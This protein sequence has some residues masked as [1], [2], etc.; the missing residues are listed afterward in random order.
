MADN[1]N[2]NDLLTDKIAKFINAAFSVGDPRAKLN[3]KIK[4]VSYAA[5][6]ADTPEKKAKLEAKLNKLYEK[7]QKIDDQGV[8]TGQK[9]TGFLGVAAMIVAAFVKVAKAGLQSYKKSITSTQQLAKTFKLINSE[10]SAFGETLAKANAV[11]SNQ[12]ATGK[13]TNALL[14]AEKVAAN[15]FVNAIIDGINKAKKKIVEFL[16]DEDYTTLLAK[17]IVEANKMAFM[18]KGYSTSQIADYSDTAINYAVQTARGYEGNKGLNADALIESD[19]YK[20]ALER[21]N[22]WINGGMNS[23]MFQGG[24]AELLGEDY[25][26][27]LIMSAEVQAEYTKQLVDK[28]SKMGLEEQQSTLSSWENAGTILNN[29]AKNL[30]SFDEVISQDA[31]KVNDEKASKILEG[32]I[33][34]YDKKDDLLSSI[35]QDVEKIA[36]GEMDSSG[37]HEI[38][39]SD[40]GG[41]TGGEDHT[42]FMADYL[43]NKYSTNLHGTTINADTGY[44]YDER[45]GK[46]LSPDNTGTGVNKINPSF[47]STSS[48]NSSSNGFLDFLGR[49]ADNFVSILTGSHGLNPTQNANRN[50]VNPHF[51]AGGIGR[52]P[53]TNA[54]LFENGAE[55]IV[56][57]DSQEGINYMASALREAGLAGGGQSNVNVNIYGA[58]LSD[59]RTRDQIAR[60][61]GERIQTITLRE[62]GI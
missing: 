51:A 21:A 9:V 6:K 8:T 35:Q 44:W 46:H 16:E 37:R 50:A 3:S 49:I 12:E 43:Y 45:G 48:D 38:D 36:N 19:E 22:S 23:N 27:G 61:I 15:T 41:L 31:I 10:A 5:S 2:I 17:H 34:N 57:L 39:S 47:W 29:I 62:G 55:A 59:E 60:D 32:V 18:N 54:T 52:S 40:N 26:P 4:Q 13:H 28:L 25:I 42:D 56:P 11:A 33:M 20:E 14:D 53:V 30:Y 24:L 58:D 7:K 1:K